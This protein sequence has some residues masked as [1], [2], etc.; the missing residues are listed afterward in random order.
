L[1]GRARDADIDQFGGLLLAFY[2]PPVSAA[3]VAGV[4]RSGALKA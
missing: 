4:S 1:V 2:C 3:P